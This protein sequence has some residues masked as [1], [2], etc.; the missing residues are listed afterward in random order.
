MVTMNGI[1]DDTVAFLRREM[2]LVQPVAL[3]TILLPNVILRLLSPKAPGEEVGGLATI[4]VLACV[5]VMIVGQLGLIALVLRAGTSVGDALRLGASRL[6]KLIGISIILGIGFILLLIPS[7]VGM[8]QA[9]VDPAVPSTL[10]LAPG[11]TWFLMLVASLVMIWL[12]VRLTTLNALIVDRNPPVFQ[13]LRDAFAMTRQ[14]VWPLLGVIVLYGIVTLV[15]ST[16]AIFVFGTLFNAIAG[17]IGSPFVGEVLT[18]LIAGLVTA[19]MSTLAALF[20]AHFYRRVA[21]QD[22]AP[23][24]H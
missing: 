5:L 21:G 2:A 23:V 12:G 4:A 10:A 1:W 18:A 24:L 11:W 16:A 7:V 6:P 20:M 19:V 13:S 9:G 22:N 14:Y 17:A 15:I 3:A 8:M